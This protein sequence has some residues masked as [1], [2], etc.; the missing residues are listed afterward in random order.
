VLVPMCEPTYT[1]FLMV[2]DVKHGRVYYLDV[3]RAPEH[4]EQTERNMQTILLMLGQFFK[5]ESNMLS[6]SH[7]S[8]DSTTWG[9]I[10]YPD[11]V[12]SY[13]E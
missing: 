11:G 7:V 5:L 4:K 3:T 8:A 12:P 9:P 10:K 2:V 13:P 6:F 1:W